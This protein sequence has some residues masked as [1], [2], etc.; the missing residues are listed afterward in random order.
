MHH[1]ILLLIVQIRIYPFERYSRVWLGDEEIFGMCKTS[2]IR[3][4]KQ[5]LITVCIYTYKVKN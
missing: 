3:R 4:K 2:Q 5:T 1:G